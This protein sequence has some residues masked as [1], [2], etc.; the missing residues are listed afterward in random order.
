MIKG[1]CKEVVVVKCNGK[2]VDEAIFIL[3]KSSKKTSRKEILDEANAII[4]EKTSLADGKSLKRK[5]SF[6]RIIHDNNF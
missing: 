6:L 4:K 1:I 5:E 2:I 3:K